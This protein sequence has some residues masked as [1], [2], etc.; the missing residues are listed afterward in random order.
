MATQNKRRGMLTYSVIVMFPRGNA[1]SY[2][3]ARTRVLLEHF[4]LELFDHAPY[5][6]DQAPSNYHLFAYLKKLL[7]SQHFNN[8]EFMEVVKHG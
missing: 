3:A 5:S 8:N 1:C 2:T 4:N 6:R 7:R